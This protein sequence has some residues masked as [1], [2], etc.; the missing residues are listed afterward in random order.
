MTETIH[1]REFLGGA[2]AA[3]FDAHS[4]RSGRVAFLS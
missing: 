1:R 4:V 3:R 2:A